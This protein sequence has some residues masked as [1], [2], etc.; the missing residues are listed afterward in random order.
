MCARTLCPLLSSTRN[1]ALGSG[2][3]TRPSTSMA[4]SFLAI[5]STIFDSER[6]RKSRLIP[7]ATVRARIPSRG[8]SGHEERAASASDLLY[9][10]GLRFAKTPKTHHP[11]E[12]QRQRAGQA[13]DDARNTVCCCQDRSQDDRGAAEAGQ[14][15][16]EGGG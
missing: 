14:P 9:L 8:Q 12:H 3:T 11:R 7:S 13:Y 6:R 10:A 2:S 4:P 16:R 1:M 15:A 5:A